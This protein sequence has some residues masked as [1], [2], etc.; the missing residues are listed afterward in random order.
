MFLGIE[1]GGTKLQLGVG[2]GDGTL[3]GLWRGAV[4]VA[5]GAA[6]IRRQI[7]AAVPE[8]LTR[9]GVDRA[10]VRGVG[11]GFGG[12]VD[13]ATRTVIKSHQ[14]EGWD[15]FPL[16]EWIA[17]MLGWPAVL[18]NDADV[19]GLAE[20]L[21][22]AGKGLSPIFYITIGS[23]IGGGLIINGEI[24]RGC[25]RGAAE[26]GHLRTWSLGPGGVA[27]WRP[28]EGYA[29]GWGIGHVARTR[30]ARGEGADSLLLKLV[31]CD[32]ERITAREVAQAAEE[33][34]AFAEAV[35]QEARLCLAQA[36]CHVI[37][38]LCPRRIII[39]GGV[40]LMGEKLLFEPLRRLVAENVFQPFA[41]CYD[42]VPA[43]L[44]EEVV[45]HG[46]LALARRRL[47]E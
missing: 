7:T 29:S 31:A 2:P 25:G 14:I 24:Y 39:G 10:Q 15:S 19:A 9:A 22:G 36:I 17:D 47:G 21:F 5:A 43:A 30:L 45:V 28:L 46:A 38:L 20:A 37:A 41:D 11:I 18:G 3:A 4:D 35:L 12:P 26:I 1:I 27:E 23:G 44:G 16:A 32:P 13:D 6:G 42:I 40:S 34:D 33:G 8:L